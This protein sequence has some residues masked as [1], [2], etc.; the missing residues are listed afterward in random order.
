[1]NTSFVLNGIQIEIEIGTSWL[2]E[3]VEQKPTYEL[4]YHNPTSYCELLVL[5]RL[6]CKSISTIKATNSSVDDVISVV[7][8]NKNLS[9]KA[10]TH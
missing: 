7:L 2:V 4:V 3:V 6:T 8:N 5:L 1:M 10:S 9:L